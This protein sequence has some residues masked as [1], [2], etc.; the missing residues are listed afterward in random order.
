MKFSTALIALFAAIATAAPV[1][2]TADDVPD[3]SGRYIIRLKSGVSQTKH[4]EFVRDLHARSI[5]KRQDG[6]RW[7]G[8][9][10]SFGFGKFHGYSGHFDD[11][12][13]KEIEASDDVEMVEA[14]QVWTTYATQTGAPYGI[15]AL[16]SRN[17]GST[18]YTYDTTAQGTFGYVVDTGINTA[19]TAFGGRASNGYNAVGGAFTDSVGH[20]THVAGTM[21]SDRFGVAKQSNLIAVKVFAGS[22]GSTATILEGFDWAVNDIITKGRQNK[23]VINMSLGGGNSAAFTAAVNDAFDDG[24]VSVVA[25]GNSNTN[26]AS[27]SPANA[28]K[29]I[30]VGSV[31]S[32]RA[33]STFS[34]YGTV[35]DVFAS[36]TGILSTWIGSNSATN[37]ISGTSMASPHVAGLVNYLQ[38]LVPG[39]AAAITNQIVTR[40]IKNVVTNP[41]S[42]SNN[43]LAFNGAT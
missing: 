38:A 16:S 2:Q 3:V 9:E 28:A 18:T 26:A 30:T 40:S 4:M 15:A 1:A 43:R 32:R 11:D 23:A 22:S 34:N 42:G 33:R 20:G 31:D 39:N 8:V 25:A 19:H 12:V 14:D 6:R 29:A 5:E 35:V 36:G 27:T 17:A 7:R 21:G 37:T 10:K 13:V 24:V 41:G